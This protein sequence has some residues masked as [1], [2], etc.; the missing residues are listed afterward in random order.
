MAFEWLQKF[1]QNTRKEANYAEKAL[2]AYALGMK[3]KGAIVGVR[4]CTATNGCDVARRVPE[5]KIYHPDNAP[6]LPLR[7]CP[8]GNGCGCVYQPVMSYEQENEKLKDTR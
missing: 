4:I 5:H 7:G 6:R 8:F 3:A 2:A 1:R